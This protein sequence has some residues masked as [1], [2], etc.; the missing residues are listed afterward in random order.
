[1]TDTPLGRMGCLGCEG[2][3]A[4]GF[5]RCPHCRTRSPMFTGEEGTEDQMPKVTSGGPS[6]AAAV[7]VEDDGAASVEFAWG[8]EEAAE[9]SVDAVAQ[10]AEG[11]A[12]TTEVVGEQG[13]EL[14]EFPA[15]D[16][17]EHVSAD[18][19]AAGYTDLSFAQLRA[20]AK[21]RGLPAGGTAVELAARLAGHD[22]AAQPAEQP[23]IAGE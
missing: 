9:G 18:D 16:V 14:T 10:A 6:N 22:A 11:S 4:V 3:Y 21:A 2:T 17:L 1:M 7:V 23:P 19:A 20:E 15:G 5:L 13:P 12:A 8:G